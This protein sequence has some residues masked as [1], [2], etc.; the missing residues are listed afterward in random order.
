MSETVRTCPVC[1]CR[2]PG[3]AETCIYCGAP[4]EEAASGAGEPASD[5]GGA[6]A[7]AGHARAG[8]RHARTEK[9]SAEETPAEGRHARVEDDEQELFPADFYERN[10]AVHPHGTAHR[11]ERSRHAARPKRSVL[12]GRHRRAVK[13]GVCIGAVVLV[14]LLS[15]VVVLAFMS[16][17]DLKQ[18]A[19]AAQAAQDEPASGRV[20]DIPAA[21]WGGS[22]AASDGTT[23]YW[24][25][26]EGIY[27]LEAADMGKDVDARQLGTDAAAGMYVVGSQ[28]VYTCGDEV[29][30]LP[31]GA[32]GGDSSPISLFTCGDAEQIAGFA[33]HG[34]VGYLLVQTGELEGS[35][36]D[37]DDAADAGEGSDGSA[38]SSGDGSAAGMVLLKANLA[39]EEPAWTQVHAVEGSQG[40]LFDVGD[41]LA[42]M[43]ATETTWT[44]AQTDY[45]ALED[46]GASAASSVFQPIAQAD[47][48]LLAA[49]YDGKNIYTTVRGANGTP[50]TARQEL[51]GSFSDYT[52]VAGTPLFAGGP[53]LCVVLTDAGGL[54]WIDSQ[55]GFLHDASELVDEAGLS[56]TPAS[57]KI[58]VDG[59]TVWVLSMASDG[60]GELVYLDCSDDSEGI[61]SAYGAS[62]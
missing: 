8:G 18:R 32:E 54:A 10:A 41:Q 28:L 36:A 44:L 23:L 6:Y 25:S 2:V 26:G 56:V 58:A 61:V 55:T 42:I 53:S 15:V 52:N 50:V 13:I 39:S 49:F 4:L 20:A 14:V 22:F 5:G 45:G 12:D 40:W 38:A 51:S 19:E 48:Q 11:K 35:P 37:S 9:V 7:E 31:T 27:A 17:L 21:G 60:A 62:A 3:E 29:R 24:S 59:A 1:G 34:D 57:S 16:D 43:S 46:E 47:E 30:T 33:V